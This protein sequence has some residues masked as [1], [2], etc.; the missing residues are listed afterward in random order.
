MALIQAFRK[1]GYTAENGNRFVTHAFRGLFSTTAYNILGASSL[2]VELQLA[3]VEQNK[4]KAA[5]HKTSLRTA[6]AERRAL[7]QQYADY[8]D[9]LREGSSEGTN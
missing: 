8:L 9:E 1:M 2:A 5:Y 3:H 6:L 4:V 7:L